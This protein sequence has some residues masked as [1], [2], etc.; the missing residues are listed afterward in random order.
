M[1]VFV[2]V[3]VRTRVCVWYWSCSYAIEALLQFMYQEIFMLFRQWHVN[4]ALIFA[5]YAGFLF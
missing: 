1:F 3:C 4:N 2:H 5:K